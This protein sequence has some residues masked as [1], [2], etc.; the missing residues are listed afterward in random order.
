MSKRSD[1][2]AAETCTAL[3]A[4]GARRARGVQSFL[5]LI[6]AVTAIA[7]AGCG[8]GVVRNEGHA[9]EPTIQDGERMVITRHI[10]RLE[11]GQIVVFRY[12]QDVSKS[13]VKRIVGLPGEEIAVRDGRVV[14]N[15]LTIDEP[16]VGAENWSADTHGSRTIPPGEYF[17]LG[18]NRRNSSDSRHWGTVKRELIWAIV[19]R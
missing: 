17:V 14:I 15:G 1:P 10:D 9:M 13:F 18:D 16:Y 6:V 7:A 4:P 5:R 19:P 8:A 12:P 11:R 2:V 3:G